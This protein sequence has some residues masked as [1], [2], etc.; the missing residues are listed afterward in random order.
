MTDFLNP[1]EIQIVKDLANYYN[2]KFF[3]S[4]TFDNE[5]YGRVILAP[6]YYELDED[7]FEI[8]RLE[9]SYARQFNKLTHPKILGALL[10]QLVLNVK[11]LEMLFLMKKAEFNLTLLLI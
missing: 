6:D 7:D 4:S 8:K 1:R 9:I 10:N 3:V 2:L 5:E 11:Y